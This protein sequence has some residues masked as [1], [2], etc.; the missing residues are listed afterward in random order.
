MADHKWR[1]FCVIVDENIPFSVELLPDKTVDELKDAIKLKRPNEFANIDATH[2]T[3]YRANIPADKELSKHVMK[4]INSI[5]APEELNP[6]DELGDLFAETPAQKTVQILVQPPPGTLP[7][8]PS[9]R[10]LAD[11]HACYLV[12][13]GPPRK[14]ARKGQS[15]LSHLRKLLRWTLESRS[16][17]SSDV[18]QL[19]YRIV[20]ISFTTEI[21]PVHNS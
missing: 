17:G 3:L 11:H 18:G 14:K 2:L 19:S 16:S 7:M 21:S 5:P 15:S 4:Q 20:S 1:I 13:E 8:L 10:T 9:G 6:I 12:D